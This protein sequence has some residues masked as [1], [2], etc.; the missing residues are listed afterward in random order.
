MVRTVKIFAVAFLCLTGALA[1][2]VAHAGTFT[3]G[4][5]ATAADLGLNSNAGIIQ[6][7]NVGPADS[8]AGTNSPTVGAVTFAAD[9]TGIFASLGVNDF[10][11]DWSNQNFGDAAMNTLMGSFYYAV[12]PNAMSYTI[13]GLTSGTSYELQ[14]LT[15]DGDGGNAVGPTYR[16]PSTITAGSDSLSYNYAATMFAGTGSN[17]LTDHGTFVDYTFTG[18][19]SGQLAVSMTPATGSIVFSAFDVRA[20]PTPEPSSCILFG[21]GALGLIAAARRRRRSA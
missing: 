15:Y 11:G 6:A 17:W 18:P 3:T 12:P 9:T 16:G 1:S 2:R 4:T 8:S 5:F 20:L 14:L 19:M 21:L 7:V 10:G 13:T